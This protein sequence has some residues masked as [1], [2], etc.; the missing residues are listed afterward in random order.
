M[1]FQEYVINH[2]KSARMNEASS[3]NNSIRIQERMLDQEKEASVT[4]TTTPKRL[5]ALLLQQVERTKKMMRPIDQWLAK[6][7]QY[8]DC[9]STEEYQA[10]RNC[11]ETNRIDQPYTKVIDCRFQIESFYESLKE[12]ETVSWNERHQ[13]RRS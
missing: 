13:V 5:Q 8:Q 12:R 11:G 7:L 6:R 1:F 9:P 4:M 10:T 2:D 3:S